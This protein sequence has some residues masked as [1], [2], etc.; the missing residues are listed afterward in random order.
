MLHT[1]KLVIV[2]ILKQWIN[3]HQY[4]SVEERE[5][6]LD[7][8]CIYSLLLDSLCTQYM[9]HVPWYMYLGTCTFY[10]LKKKKKE[11]EKEK[12]KEKYAHDI[13]YA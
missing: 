6:L 1:V 7:K 4:V 12:E 10:I 11:K 9:S 3:W 2:V 8:V 13:Q 5:W